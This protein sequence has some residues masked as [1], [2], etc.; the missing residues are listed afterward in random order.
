MKTVVYI[1]ILLVCREEFV[2]EFLCLASKVRMCFV[3][4]FCNCNGFFGHLIFSLH[5]VVIACILV[6]SAVDWQKKLPWS[7]SQ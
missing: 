2:R 3:V 1:V 4:G 5:T 7:A 6:Y